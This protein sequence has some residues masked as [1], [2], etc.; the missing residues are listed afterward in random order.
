MIEKFLY[1]IAAGSVTLKD[2]FRSSTSGSLLVAMEIEK[3]GGISMVAIAINPI[4][5]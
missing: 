4:K 2:I 3:P 1:K 5:I